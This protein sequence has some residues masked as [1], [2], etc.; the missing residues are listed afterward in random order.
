LFAIQFAFEFEGVFFVVSA[1]HGE[2]EGDISFF[3]VEVGFVLAIPAMVG[4]GEVLVDREQSGAGLALVVGGFE[5]PMADEGGVFSF[6]VG[7]VGAS[8]GGEF[9]H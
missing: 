5:E 9:A 4:G 7:V 8:F 2:F 3:D 6:A 1:S